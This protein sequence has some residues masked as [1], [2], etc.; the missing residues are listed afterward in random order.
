MADGG[1]ISLA[2]IGMMAAGSVLA[3]SGVNDP[4]GGPIGVVRDI[5]QGKTPTPGVQ[6][7][8][9]PSAAGTT[10][11]GTSSGEGVPDRN[12]PAGVRSKV[13]AIAR[14]YLG[15][16]YRFGGTSRQGI[17]CSGLVLVSYRDGAGIKL[18]HLATAQAARGRKIPR[19]QA[20]PG[21]LA[22]YGAP[23]NYPH[24]G[25]IIDAQTG[26]FAPTWGKVVQYQTWWER[27]VSNFGYP[28][29]IRILET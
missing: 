3:Y 26:I 19:E 12:I 4:V 5:L 2:G 1:G 25:L 7:V 18:P 21:D 24:I 27:K 8:T 11:P 29:V 23:G 15:V 13:I 28:D 17:D 9:A 16:P 14:T 20:Q 10:T 6:V 22:A